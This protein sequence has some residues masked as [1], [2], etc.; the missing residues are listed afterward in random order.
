MP[1]WRVARSL[2]VLLDQIN[3][4]YPGRSKA[5]DG[6]IGDVAHVS[7]TSDHNPHIQLGGV[8]IVSARDFTHD[9]AAGFDAHAFADALRRSGDLRIKY[10]I[11]DRR[12]FSSYVSGGRAP[13]EWRPYVGSNPH[14]QHVHVSVQP[15]ANLF[16]LPTRWAAVPRPDR[17]SPIPDI[18][19]YPMDT[20]DLRGAD[21][22]PVRG[23]HVPQL[24][25]LLLAAQHGPK[26]LIGDDG[27]PDGIAGPGTRVC[28]GDFQRRTGTGNRDGSPDYICG[29]GTWRALITG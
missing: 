9:P 3:E 18:E 24:Q 5:S 11:S 22:E 17:F 12:M 15:V 25:G 8:G 2:D 13:W 4:A 19:E 29:A 16:D 1:D 10:V 28:L 7:R 14:T 26:G 20:L 6:S 23:R 27:R 21:K